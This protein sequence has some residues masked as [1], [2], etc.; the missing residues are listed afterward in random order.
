MMSNDIDQKAVAAECLRCGTCCRQ[1]GPA[2]HN[3][4]IHLLTNAVLPREQ[5]VTIRP[6]EPA[7]N[8]LADKV[9]ASGSEFIKIKGQGNS[10]RCTFFDQIN[11]GC[12]IYQ[13]RPLECR[14]LFCRATGPVAEILGQNLLIRQ[15]LLSENDPLL[16][17]LARQEQECPF[18]LVNELLT[19]KG[20]EIS[21][22]LTDLVRRDLSIRDI[23]LR[24][25]PERQAEELFLFGRPLFLVLAPY[26]FRLVERRGPVRLEL[27]NPENIPNP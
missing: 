10:W 18:R 3:E 17:L 20:D 9:L 2:L 6:E 19:S 26:G 14:L 1:G 15:S 25:F 5:L 13:T 12:L 27:V 8:P 22:K 11:N 4:D 7:Y 16:P 23:F 24:D 21:K